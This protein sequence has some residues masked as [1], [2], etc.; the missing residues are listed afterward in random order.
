[1]DTPQI[2]ILDAV[3]DRLLEIKL[4]NGYSEALA[5]LDRARLIPFKGD[6]FPAINY[7]ISDDTRVAAGHGWVDRQATMV[8]EYYSKTRDEPFTDVAFA[9]AGAAT[10]ALLRAPTA[11]AVTDDPDLTLGGLVRSIQL[12]SITPQIGQGQSPW[13]GVVLTYNLGYRVSASNPLT[14]VP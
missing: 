1:M 11:P 2:Q 13:C 8:L 10:V 9:L 14:L 3:K 6:D 12:Q 7:W 5:K 4:D